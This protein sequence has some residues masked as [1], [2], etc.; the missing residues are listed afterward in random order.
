MPLETKVGG[1][2]TNLTRAKSLHFLKLS[3]TSLAFIDTHLLI[4]IIALYAASLGADVGMIGLIVGLY[5]ITNI[6]ANIFFGP[7]IDRV[8]FKKPL[9][10]GL[11]GDAI[12]MFCYSICRV[13]VHLV[14]VRGIHGI[15]GGLAGPATMSVFA[16]DAT[17]GRRGG[18]MGLYGMSLAIATLVGYGLSGVLSSR[19]GYDSVFYFG[20]GL[21]L[22]GMFLAIAMPKGRVVGT[23]DVKLSAR[24]QTKKICEL[25]SRRGLIA[26]Y[27]SIF[28]IYFAFGSVVTLLPLHVRSLG[29]ETFH[30]SMLLTTFVVVFILLQFPS[31][32]IS[33]R[34]G[35]WIPIAIGLFCC[36][37]SLI[38]MPRLGT[39]ITL[40]TIMALYGAGYALVFPSIS[41]LVADH[42]A[43]EEYGSAVGIFHALLTAGVGIGAPVMGWVAGMVGI[44]L[45]LALSSGTV[46]IVLVMILVMFGRQKHPGNAKSQT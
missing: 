36:V 5:S 11:L 44:E 14:I 40:A 33:D 39:F 42:A 3:V 37:V 18:M 26:S 35:R 45:S 19:L 27:C 41:A 17:E 25:L 4:P 12:S 2:G 13:P 7:V 30:V 46:A 22:V 6:L 29:M 20:A 23:P 43:S 32:V 16:K 31:G 34:V 38:I 21:L 24:E 9:I 1:G 28:V 8:G 15:T 10:I